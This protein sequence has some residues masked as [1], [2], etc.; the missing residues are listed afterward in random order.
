MY[1]KETRINAGPIHL[2]LFGSPLQIWL[3]FWCPV[4]MYLSFW[5][6]PQKSRFLHQKG[7][8]S[9][10]IDHDRCLGG[11]QWEPPVQSWKHKEVIFHVSSHGDAKSF[12]GFLQKLD[13]WPK[14]G[15]LD[16]KKIHFGHFGPKKGLPSG[17]MGIYLNYEC[18]KSCFGMCLQYVNTG[19][20]AVGQ[21]KVCYMAV[22]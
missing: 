17:Q 21:K 20:N 8:L 18:V 16:P 1:F 4:M 15:I 2:C 11:S 3:L 6:G 19:M 10:K 14:N 13:F 5:K 22:A 9:S 7:P 12:G